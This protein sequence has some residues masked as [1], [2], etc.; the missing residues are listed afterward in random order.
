LLYINRNYN[1]FQIKDLSFVSNGGV[2]VDVQQGIS[3]GCSLSPLMGALYLKTLDDESTL[4][5]LK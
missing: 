1:F 3:L 5:L 2:Y 4:L